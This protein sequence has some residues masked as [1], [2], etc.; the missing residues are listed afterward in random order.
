MRNNLEPERKLPRIVADNEYM[1]E[2]RREPRT[3]VMTLVEVMWEDETGT[4]RI[5]AAIMQDR[6]SGGISIRIG[7]AIQVG[8]RLTIKSFREQFSGVVT[9]CHSDA[10]GYF[11]GIKLDPPANRDPESPAET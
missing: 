10:K 4:A 11:L 9:H 8:S 2:M 1:D 6:S 5:A 7:N 3:A